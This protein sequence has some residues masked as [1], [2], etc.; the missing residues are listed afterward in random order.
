[1]VLVDCGRKVFEEKGRS[2]AARRARIGCRKRVARRIW[3][4]RVLQLLVSASVGK[5]LKELVQ[6]LNHEKAMSLP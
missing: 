2:Y 5:G 4:C 1:M 3:M 6:H